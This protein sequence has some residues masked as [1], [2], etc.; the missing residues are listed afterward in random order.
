MHRDPDQQGL[1]RPEHSFP[2][3]NTPQHQSKIRVLVV[4]DDVL[5][6]AGLRAVLTRTPGMRVTGEAATGDEAAAL[7]ERLR[8][9]VLLLEV[10]PW[11]HRTIALCSEVVR[12]CRAGRLLVIVYPNGHESRPHPAPEQGRG[13]QCLSVEPL[14]LA[15]AIRTVAE[16]GLVRTAVLT[17]ESK[18]QV[19]R[20]GPPVLPQ[21][22]TAREEQILA[23]AKHGCTYKE[24]ASTTGLSTVTVKASLGHIYKKIQVSVRAEVAVFSTSGCEIARFPAIHRHTRERVDRRRCYGF[25]SYCGL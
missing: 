15:H 3:R 16:E 5:V 8:P 21:K 20:I 11:D 4:N 13:D 10:R 14:E 22:L 9:D 7:A 18:A 12:T 23:V 6:R 17:G 25:D 19:D 2:S 1:R 24:I